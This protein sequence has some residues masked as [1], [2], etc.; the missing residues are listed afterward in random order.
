METRTRKL[1][2]PNSGDVFGSGKS[3]AYLFARFSS[4]GLLLSAYQ[5]S[6]LWTAI[7]SLPVR[8]SIAGHIIS[9][10]KFLEPKTVDGTQW[11]VAVFVGSGPMTAHV[12]RKFL[13]NR[14]E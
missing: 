11:P 10:P 6:P 13:S 2:F 4:R 14:Q 1:I 12:L 8:V 3:R 5:V 7:L 9:S